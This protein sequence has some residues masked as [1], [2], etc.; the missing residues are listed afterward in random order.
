MVLSLR[1]SSNLCVLVM[2]TLVDK[3]R[4]GHHV[5]DVINIKGSKKS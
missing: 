2:C 4:C 3:L 5:C 1:T